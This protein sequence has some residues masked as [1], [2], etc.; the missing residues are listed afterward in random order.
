MIVLDASTALEA[1]LYEGPSREIVGAELL[2]APH[3]IDSEVVH[4]L[5]KRQRAGRIDAGQAG[6]TVQLWRR[7]GITRHPVD[8]LL[9]RVWA[10]RDNVTP[11]D[12]AYV[13]LAERLG[14]TLVTADAR[15]SRAS[16]LRCPVTVVPR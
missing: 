2:E 13:A 8:T 12:A 16:G 7:I 4:G 15:L 10:L 14:C 5:L 3:L 1:L 9:D 11:Y 6:A